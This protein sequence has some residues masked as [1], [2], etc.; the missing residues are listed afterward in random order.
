M[1][2]NIRD[3]WLG[4]FSGGAQNLSREWIQVR[5][6]FS[7]QWA[8]LEFLNFIDVI[9]YNSRGWWWWSIKANRRS[10]SIGISQRNGLLRSLLLVAVKLKTTTLGG[11]SRRRYVES[12]ALL[13]ALNVNSKIPYENRYV[14]HLMKNWYRVGRWRWW[15]FKLGYYKVTPNSEAE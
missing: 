2:R 12:L 1:T 14:R 3:V 9:A 6:S 4:L 10:R 7:C 8:P 15:P 13:L 5:G 11:S